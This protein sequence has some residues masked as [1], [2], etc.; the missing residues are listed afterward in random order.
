MSIRT[1]YRVA[2]AEG[3]VRHREVALEVARRLRIVVRPRPVLALG[4]GRARLLAGRGG[5]RLGAAV[6]KLDKVFGGVVDA[7]E[8]RR[9]IEAAV[10]VVTVVVPVVRCIVIGDFRRRVEV[11]LV[12]VL[13]VD[14]HSVVV[15][16]G[17]SRRRDRRIA[18][19]GG[20]GVD[21]HGCFPAAGDAGLVE[22]PDVGRLR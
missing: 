16:R 22:A 10:E 3:L 15:E 9:R 21:V 7:L 8:V 20:V 14:H 18:F 19:E 13:V 1:T 5:A 4:V 6:R 11:E 2:V 12:R 17:V